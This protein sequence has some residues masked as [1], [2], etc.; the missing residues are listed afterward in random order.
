MEKYN[1]QLRSMGGTMSEDTLLIQQTLAGD[2]QAFHHLAVKYQSAIYSL[3][4][5]YV[6]NPDDAQEIMQDVFLKAYQGLSSLRRSERFRFWLYQLA[7]NQ[8]QDWK[9]K[10]QAEFQ[11]LTDKTA[12]KSYPVDELLILRETLSKIMQAID[13]LPETEKR[14]LK[15]RYLDDSSYA[16]MQA[17]HGLSYKALNMRLLR[18][19]QKVR[20]RVEKLLAGIGLFSW[21][22]ALEKMLLGGVEAMKISVKVKIITIG[23]AAVLI[24]SGT[25]AIIWHYQQS[26]QNIIS[27]SSINRT[28][29]KASLSSDKEQASDKSK[30]AVDTNIKKSSDKQKIYLKNVKTDEQINPA[31][32]VAVQE[33]KEPEIKETPLQKYLR[34]M[35][36]PEYKADYEKAVAPY[37]ANIERMETEAKALYENKKEL[38]NK[39]IVATGEEKDKIQ[40]EL[41][42][43]DTDY[44][45]TRIKLAMEISL[46]HNNGEPVRFKYLT[47]EEWH[48]AMF[49]M[50]EAGTMPPLPPQPTTNEERESVDIFIFPEDWTEA[51]KRLN[52]MGIGLFNPPPP[53]KA[54][55]EKYV[56]KNR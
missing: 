50:R 42:K 20:A 55:Y 32:E 11:Q 47:Y 10:N 12:D 40:K 39:L 46:M 8:C 1:F 15:E 41:D 43:A 17:K 49:Q 19:K 35:D 26:T 6:R 21:H 51:Y 2:E 48:E 45:E 28:I 22:D 24:L 30:T 29:Q 36:S 27:D 5:S 23:V 7:R 9:R 4:L 44:K 25:G 53:S 37:M 18:A 16:E 3:I 13:E 31:R 52:A 54:L 34:I 33:T 56:Y 38:E 14:I